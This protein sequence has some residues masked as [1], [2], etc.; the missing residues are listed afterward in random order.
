MISPKP[1]YREDHFDCGEEAAPRSRDAG[2][3]RTVHYLVAYDIASP[4]RLRRVARV[5]ED[6]GVRIQKSIFECDLDGCTFKALW[7]ALLD[8]IDPDEDYLAAY[9]LCRACCEKIRM[10]G[11][12]GPRDEVA[13]WVC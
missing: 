4:K 7:D 10:A 3:A 2:V 8:E 12:A 13:A 9:P 1:S 6:Y 11:A 5:C